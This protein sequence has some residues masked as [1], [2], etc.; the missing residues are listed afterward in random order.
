MTDE[1]PETQVTLLLAHASER[2][3]E[4][5]ALEMAEVALKH[6]HTLPEGE[7]ERRIE[8]FEKAVEEVLC[9]K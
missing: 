9:L 3:I 5:C 1:I 2:T 6:L 8:A 7:R 4:Q